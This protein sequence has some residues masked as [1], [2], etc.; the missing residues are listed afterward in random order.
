[1]NGQ[2]PNNPNN[3]GA[4]SLG[5]STLGSVNQVPNP[6]GYTSVSNNQSMENQ[7]MRQNAAGEIPNASN[8]SPIPNLSGQEIVGRPEPMP[9]QNVGIN[10][11]PEMMAG[12]SAMP[13][14]SPGIDIPPMQEPVAR[15]IPGTEQ[16]FA[17]NFSSNNVNNMAMNQNNLNANGFAEPNHQENI[18]QMPPKETK[19][20]KKMSKVLFVILVI[21]LIAGVAFG[22]YYFLDISNNKVKLTT[23]TLNLGVGDNVSENISDY[24]AVTS[25]DVNSCALDITGIDNDKIGE[26]KAV[27]TCGEETYE[28]K[29]VVSDK[30]AP[31]V[32]LQPVFKEVGS[33]VTVDEFV[34]SCTDP[35]NCTTTF[36]DESKVK[37]NMA[38]AGGPYEVEIEAK[39]SAGNSEVS[40]G[41]LYVAP[42]SIFAYSNCKSASSELTEYKGVK[43]TTD[44]IPLGRPEAG[45]PSYMNIAIRRSKIVFDSKEEYDKAVGKKESKITIEGITG[46]ATYNDNNKTIYII[47]DLSN[48]TLN[49]ENNGAFPVSFA[50]FRTIYTNKGY[51]CSVTQEYT[52]EK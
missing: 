1:M 7:G 41:M 44:I 3:F 46:N 14:S 48:E 34:K 45:T 43:E 8:P 12:T 31:T 26:Y 6:N 30:T 18:G 20:K 13:G 33:T 11:S 10:T 22:V 50:D 35:S 29:V 9:N 49:S 24:V 47:S 42:Y 38:T 51:T 52:E 40:K 25:G 19:E 37:E 4:E 39:D 21:V 15:P 2:N 16:E 36:K 32:E 17:G 23:K 5:S 27:I 28:S